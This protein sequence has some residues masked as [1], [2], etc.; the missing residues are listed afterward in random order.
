MSPIV[1]EGGGETR[2]NG[3][4]GHDA[5]GMGSSDDTPAATVEQARVAKTELVRALAD[6]PGIVGV[7]IVRWESGFVIVVNLQARENS[8][9]IPE[10]FNSIPVRIKVT[11][12]VQA[13]EDS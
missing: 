7:G 5:G 12:T 11:G 9:G 6:R 3:T 8:V 13:L 1:E 4:A 10:E 2:A